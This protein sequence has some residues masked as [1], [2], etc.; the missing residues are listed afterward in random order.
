MRPELEGMRINASHGGDW[1]CSTEQAQLVAWLTGIA[2]REAL[3]E[4]GISLRYAK[5]ETGMVRGLR[6]EFLARVFERDIDS[7][8]D[9]REGEAS[10]VLDLL[11]THGRSVVGE[12]MITEEE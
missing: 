7:S 1:L 12:W 9:L 3:A 6:L 4:S 11:D 5:A 2:V 8:L 10:A